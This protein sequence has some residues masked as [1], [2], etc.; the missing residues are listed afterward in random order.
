MREQIF[1]RFTGINC[2]WVDPAGKEGT[3]YFGFADK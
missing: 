2:A 3:E 1:K